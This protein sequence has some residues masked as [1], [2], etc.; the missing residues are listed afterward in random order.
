[1]TVKK[2]NAKV[3]SG[4]LMS[5]L[6]LSLLTVA[7]PSPASADVPNCDVQDQQCWKDHYG[8]TTPDYGWPSQRPPASTPGPTQQPSSPSQSAPTPPADDGTA[9]EVSR[10]SVDEL[11]DEDYSG[12]EDVIVQ[13]TNGDIITGEVTPDEKRE[14]E[15]KPEV[16]VIEQDSPVYINAESWG[17]DRINQP[18]LPLDGFYDGGTSGEGVRVYVIDTGV[19]YRSSQF[20]SIERS[21]FDA[22][23]GDTWSSGRFVITDGDP[24]DC[25]GH[26]T[27]VAGT[28]ASRDYG[29]APGATIVG[30]RVLNCSGSGSTV[31]VINGILWSIEDAAGRPAVINM[32]LGGSFSSLLNETVQDAVDAGITV[33]V[34][35]GNDS[36]D[37]SR[38]S[39]ASATNAITVA[40]STSADQRSYFSNYGP[41]VDI[42]A[43]GSSITSLKIGS[44]TAVFSGT[45]MAAPHVAGAAAAFLGSSPTSSPAQV[46]AALKA[47]AVSRVSHAG[48]TSALLQVNVATNPNPE[49]TP[50]PTPE[51]SPDP[52]PT[53]DPEPPAQSPSPP[54]KPSPPSYS[55]PN[56][57]VAVSPSVATQGRLVSL[58]GSGLSSASSVFFGDRE[59]ASFTVISSRFVLATVPDMPEGSYSIHVQLDPSIGR[60][61]YAG[62]F[63]V[64]APEPV[65]VPPTPSA[66]VTVQEELPWF[67]TLNPEPEPAAPPSTTVTRRGKSVALDLVVPDQDPYTSIR[68]Y[69]YKR[70]KDRWSRV[71]Y[72]LVNLSGEYSFSIP[73]KKHGRYKVVG[74]SILD[75]DTEI[76]SEFRIYKKPRRVAKLPQPEAR[77]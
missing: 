22:V 58:T 57:V 48:T 5:A 73:V 37:A 10:E 31:G 16:A 18:A 45:S 24:M 28:V 64:L 19:D 7:G 29:V 1:M 56:E 65:Y 55:V 70:K 21:G 74:Y 3:A 27:H 52:E 8:L 62:G 26:G 12:E 67:L 23:D 42:F 34:A 15:S 14:L 50:E 17:L 11:L 13:L 2:M 69:K 38:Y 49:P 43:P 6:V 59:A 44:G 30:V 46:D 33:V 66:P 32:S 47:A 71:R 54:A 35:A 9:S 72:A 63:T 60:V 4:G 20:A 77:Q 75:D 39:P 76:L 41:L 68:V 51:P 61:S 53:P 25:H 36:S 40:S